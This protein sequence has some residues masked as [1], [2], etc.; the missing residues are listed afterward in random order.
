MQQ[1]SVLPCT[2]IMMLKDKIFVVRS[3]HCLSLYKCMQ[4]KVSAFFWGTF[5][6]IV[7]MV[8]LLVVQ[9]SSSY[10]TITLC[11]Y[12]TTVKS[13]CTVTAHML[14]T[15]LIAPAVFCP[16]VIPLQPDLRQAQYSSASMAAAESIQLLGRLIHCV[17]TCVA[18][19]IAPPS[20]VST[21]S[22]WLSLSRSIASVS[23]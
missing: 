13:A 8:K 20:P 17:G 7:F 1:A 6:H 4:V 22:T 18:L 3:F 10:C 16:A 9:A 2:F 23:C 11:L 19:V 5:L 15:D 12:C 21:Y 14:F